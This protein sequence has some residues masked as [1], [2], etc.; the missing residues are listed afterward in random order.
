MSVNDTLNERGGKY[1]SYTELAKTAQEM[2]RVV[3]SRPGYKRLSD[4]Q[5]RE[6]RPEPRG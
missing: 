5:R 6:W 3:E 1:G 4:D 2:K